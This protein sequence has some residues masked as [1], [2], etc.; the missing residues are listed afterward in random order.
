MREKSLRSKLFLFV[1]GLMICSSILSVGMLWHSLESSKTVLLQ[2]TDTA[3]RTEIRDNITAKAGQYS[4]VVSAFINEAYRIPSSLAGMVKTGIEHSELAITRETLQTDLLNILHESEQVSSIYAQ[5]EPDGYDNRDAQWVTGDTH[6]VATKGT[7]EIYFTRNSAN[8]GK[9]EQ[10]TIDAATSNAKY[11]DKLNEFGI[12]EAEWYLCGRD[13][14]HACIME[15]YPYETS[16][17]HTELLTS[18]TMPVVVQ[19]QF[20]GIVGVDVNLPIF[21]Q[22]AE[23]LSSSLYDGKA[24]VLLLTA[25][26][27][28]I[29]SN[30]FKN[31]LGRPLKETPSPV[32]IPA[33]IPD[34]GLLQETSTDFIVY[35][36]I[37]IKQANTSWL[38]VVQVPK[39]IALASSAA[40]NSELSDLLHNT[41]LRTAGTSFLLLRIALILLRTVINSIV[42][43]IA[44]ISRHALHLASS[45]GDLTHHMEVNQHAELIE[46]VGNFNRFLDKLRAMVAGIKTVG[47][48]VASEA[49][50]MSD[51]SVKIKQNINVQHQEMNSIITAMNEM[52]STVGEVANHVNKAA[53]ET[54]QTTIA[55]TNAQN[56][57]TVAR[58]QIRDL[59]D[60]MQQANGPVGLVVQRSNN[61]N[62]IIEVIRSIA[63]QTNLLA[64][65]AAI[66]AARAGDM[67]RGFAVVADEV[68]SL[69]TKT[70]TSTDEISSLIANLQQEVTNTMNVIDSGMNT[71]EKTVNDTEHSFSTLAQVVL[72]I[73]NIDEYMNM[74]AVA[75]DEQNTVTTNVTHNLNKIN[76]ATQTLAE[77]ANYSFQRSEHL[78]IQAEK[79]EDELRHLRT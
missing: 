39:S 72:Q 64:L 19:G 43:P 48:S 78:G 73:Q 38:M 31:K 27:L 36:P 50:I 8:G 41:K 15:P 35:Y 23:S 47:H 70:R 77:L 30:Q 4:E 29:G 37:K 34:K 68:R 5:F 7:L 24:N 75:T 66:E 21:Q 69:A 49:K 59:S 18:L 1:M 17:G 32:S 55:V 63:D 25:K 22:Q 45:E 53:G 28:I 58:E 11:S 26:G 51:T 16:P 62:H 3:L 42:K 44:Q 33:Q 67:G 65:N 46:L 6:S 13:T 40:L 54:K 61:I 9:L 10:Q 74:I 60:N 52:S 20:H 76:D 2:R 12:R 14:K 57:L 79:L 56:S 71:A